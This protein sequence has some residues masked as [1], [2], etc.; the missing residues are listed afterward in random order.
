MTQ[1][2]V[3]GAHGAIFKGALW[4]LMVCLGGSEAMATPMAF[5]HHRTGGED[6]RNAAAA[7]GY[8][9]AEVNFNA[10]PD[11]AVQSGQRLDL[12][13]GVT[14][15]ASTAS[16]MQI[17]N[18]PVQHIGN[19]DGVLSQGQGRWAGSEDSV[20]HLRGRSQAGLGPDLL[21]LDFDSNAFAASL[22]V[23]AEDLTFN[24]VLWNV[25]DWYT[26]RRSIE[27][28]DDDG[29]LIVE[30]DLATYNFQQQRL[31]SF[32]TLSD[33]NMLLS[34]LYYLHGFPSDGF[35][36]SGFT[37]AYSVRGGGGGNEVPEPASLLLGLTGLIGAQ[38]ARKRKKLEILQ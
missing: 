10:I 25:W 7:A 9:T 27:A 8:Q 24:G 20:L 38:V 21:Y 5:T 29:E 17:R 15:T 34:E 18:M 3:T 33:R 12:A 22:G 4:A 14:L 11:G 32:G 36:L 37:I 31:Y 30:A 26:G 19:T 1:A 13:P 6:W 2:R 16:Q 28:F 23:A 35:F